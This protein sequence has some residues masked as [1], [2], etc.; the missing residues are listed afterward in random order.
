MASPQQQLSFSHEPSDNQFQGKL[1]NVPEKSVLLYEVLD[2]NE[3]KYEFF[4]IEVPEPFRGTG[5]ATKLAN[6]RIFFSS[7]CDTRQFAFDHALNNNWKV[8]VT[9]GYLKNKYL[10]PEKKEQYKSILI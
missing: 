5:I 2:Q 10:T 4:R 1:A 7:Y 3:K 6:V 9:C 8:I